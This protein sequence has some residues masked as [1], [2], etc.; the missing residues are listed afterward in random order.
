MALRASLCT[1]S[2][3]HLAPHSTNAAVAARAPYPACL[4]N[5]YSS[6]EAPLQVPSPREALPSPS[7]ETRAF[8][9]SLCLYNSACR[10]FRPAPLPT[11]GWHSTSAAA[12]PAHLLDKDTMAQGGAWTC[13]GQP[14]LDPRPPATPAPPPS[15]VPSSVTGL[16]LDWPGVCHHLG[17]QGHLFLPGHHPRTLF[18]R[19]LLEQV[20]VG[21]PGGAAWPWPPAPSASLGTS[22]MPRVPS[23]MAAE[24][25]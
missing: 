6:S 1:P 3:S 8:A 2:R 19:L 13:G 7:G 15:R 24:I 16:L 25:A 10:G 23:P 22:E 20:D 14:G 17:I 21:D 11:R 9:I 4:A 5:S 12:L 18:P